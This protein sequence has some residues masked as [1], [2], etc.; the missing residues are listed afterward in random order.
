[1]GGA[2]S[3]SIP[4]ETDQL[5]ATLG[6]YTPDVHLLPL[7]PDGT[8]IRFRVPSFMQDMFV[9]SL[10]DFID[11]KLDRIEKVPDSPKSD[12][13]FNFQA[14]MFQPPT[15][16]NAANKLVQNQSKLI[17]VLRIPSKDD[18][19][20]F[21]G[22]DFDFIGFET[23]YRNIGFQL[24]LSGKKDNDGFAR[25]ID[26]DLTL[27]L[28]V[29]WDNGMGYFH[30]GSKYHPLGSILKKLE[31]L[32]PTRSTLEG[33]PR[34][35]INAERRAE[36]MGMPVEKCRWTEY[37]AEK[38]N[39]KEDPVFYDKF[40]EGDF[41]WQTTSGTCFGPEK[42]D[43]GQFDSDPDEYESPNFYREPYFMNSD[44][45]MNPTNRSRL[46]PGCFRRVKKKDFLFP[47]RR[48]VR[49]RTD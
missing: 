23:T 4:D 14:R 21:H 3:K 39:N 24:T 49:Q 45:L 5:I 35:T 10:P 38:C 31:E 42:W 1:M 29:D 16:M 17:E 28:P 44:I 13:E 7:R 12:I 43:D 20:I 36:L 2:A 22:D 46:E 9:P 41:V 34:S 48:R 18:L 27:E 32:P 33:P 15:Q 37:S 8:Y 11:L 40:K 25:N 6:C 19:H 47:P 26:A 30:R